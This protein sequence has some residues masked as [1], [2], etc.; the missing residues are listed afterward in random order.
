[1]IKVKFFLLSLCAISLSCFFSCKPEKLVPNKEKLSVGKGQDALPVLVASGKVKRIANFESA[2][3]SSRH[4]D[5][6]L[7][8]NYD[9][10]RKFIG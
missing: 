5:V 4:I 1:M 3:V 8:K 7:P 2:Y 9:G 6:W 10:Q